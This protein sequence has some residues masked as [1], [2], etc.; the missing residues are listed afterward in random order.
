MTRAWI[1]VGS[2]IEPER[3]VREAVDALRREFGE[4]VISPVY[5][6]RAEGFEGEDF[7]NLVVGIDT[8][9]SPER[10][11][12]RL[13]RIED[14]QGRRRSTEKFAPRTL[15]LDLLTWGGL[16]DPDLGLPRDEILK[17]A[18]VLGPLADVAPDETCPGTARTYASLWQSMKEK[19]AVG[20]NRVEL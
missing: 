2:N 8:A 13:R 4:L 5:R 6:T 11:R 19:G 9:L 17:Y 20:M 14:E 18:F 1:S 3:N 15:D 7:L 10:V 16:V 12:E